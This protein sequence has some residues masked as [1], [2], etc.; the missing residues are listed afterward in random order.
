MNVLYVEDTEFDADLVRHALAGDA[1]RITLET[2]TTLA[3]ARARLASPAPYDL[4]LTDM[5][6]PDGH[7]LDLVAEIRAR[8]LNVAVVVLT[9]AAAAESAVAALKAGADDYLVKQPGYPR[10]LRATLEAACDHARRQRAQAA[11]RESEARFLALFEQA[12]I[13]VARVDAATGRFLRVNRKCCDLFGYGADELLAL[14]YRRLT[15]P[16]DLAASLASMKRLAAGEIPGFSM[17]KRYVR[18]DG[19]TVWAALTVS[20]MGQ[21]HGPVPH[22]IVVLEDITARKAAEAALRE[23]EDRYRDLVENSQDLICTH[24]LDGRLLSVNAAATTALGY[25]REA[26][27][28]VTLSDV[29]TPAARAQVPAYLADIRA[30]GVADG[31]MALQ[32]ADGTVLYWEFR[33]SLRDTGV[34]A[35][36]VRGIARDITARRQTER[37]LRKSD[38]MLRE[39]QRLARAGSWSVDLLSGVSWWSDEMYRIFGVDRATFTGSVA[40]A[41]TALVHPEDR[42]R[43][44]ARLRSAIATGEAIADEFRVVRPDG[45][46]IYC[47]TSAEFVSDAT[48]RPIRL[49]GST[50]DITDRQR[51]EQALQASRTNF[52]AIAD[53]SSV[54][55][56]VLQDAR[57]VFVNRHLADLVGYAVEELTGAG[58]FFPVADPEAY[59]ALL[60]QH[61]RRMAGE[62]VPSRFEGTLRTKDGRVLPVEAHAARIVWNDRPAGSVFITD[63]TQR[64]EAERERQALEAQ[65]RQAQ[66]IE[67]LGRMAGGIAHDF[68]N[69]LGAI[70]GHVD[71][72]AHYAGANP[73]AVRSI[74]GIR[75]ASHRARDLV[76]QILAF[77]RQQGVPRSVAALSPV[78]EETVSLLR[79][80]LPAIVELGGTDEGSAPMVFAD[81]TQIHQVVMNLCTNAW[82]AMHGAPG[83]IEVRLAGV[84]LGEE[85]A[86]GHFERR[87]GRYA[88]LSVTDTGCGMDDVTIG[89]MFEPFFTT[90]QP[91]EGTGLGLSVVH[92][93]VRAHGGTIDVRSEPGRG[94]TFHIYF[95][96]ADAA[97]AA[98]G[99][100]LVT[101]DPP[102]GHGRH[103]LLVDDEA[104]LV[105]LA[106]EFLQLHDYRVSG[107][108][109]P[110]EALDAFRADPAGFDAVVADL[111]MPG[112]SG[113]EFAREVARLRHDVP[114]V[115][116][117]GR[118]TDELRIQAAAAG[119]PDVMV[120]PYEL[121]ALCE[122]IDGVLRRANGDPAG[123]R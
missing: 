59:A 85:A 105:A 118:V 5:S 53:S 99:A 123:G 54:G 17:D 22:L 75:R 7:G 19:R 41:F 83:R 1:P 86:R 52:T 57:P 93:I 87:P 73:A 43:V 111:S 11:R 36:I 121:R 24:D 37:A 79:A 113:L 40:D 60:D 122:V 45:Q 69:V 9:G 55:I 110:S 108:V 12:G 14:D 70:I 74:D 88:R 42:A 112:L 4:V 16:D 32:A 29:T 95:P 38:A 51:A 76:R 3:G 31:V 49:H 116:A 20:P 34:A 67:A 65:L 68:N 77:S 117:S 98:A 119:I 33:N 97:A 89:R 35:P 82:Q 8:G 101:P 66:K 81:P 13:G 6:L 46:L 44:T 109:R 78:V 26:L 102:R 63:I 91:G 58:W 94:T 23:S 107:Y 15:H 64:V 71:L 120:K 50:Q 28:G 56:L 106:T 61:Q 80:T 18:K 25:P 100:A 30:R 2:V 103:V 104:E 47:A 114:V 10:H 84:T 21:E 62:D 90:K 115:L 72:A 92:G 39:A 27:L 96:A 48:G